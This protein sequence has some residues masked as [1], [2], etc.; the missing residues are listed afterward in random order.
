MKPAFFPYR[1]LVH[2]HWYRIQNHPSV[3]VTWT[4]DNLGLLR[5]SWFL[6]GWIPNQIAHSLY[7][8]RHVATHLKLNKRNTFH[9][10][11]IVIQ[12]YIESKI[13]TGLLDLTSLIRLGFIK[14]CLVITSVVQDQFS[15]TWCD[16][17]VLSRLLEYLSPWKK[18]CEQYLKGSKCC[19]PFRSN[20]LPIR[21]FRMLKSVS[22]GSTEKRRNWLLPL[23]SPAGIYFKCGKFLKVRFPD[24]PLSWK[25]FGW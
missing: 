3:L 9:L 5:F 17:A 10:G 13:L 18:N 6:V 15:G 7:L 11:Q 24:K 12:N 22:E 14:N 4:M 1:P 25:R 16:G 19:Y 20:A 23:S 21:F 8:P 2:E